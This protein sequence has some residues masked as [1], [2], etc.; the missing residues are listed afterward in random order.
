[1]ALLNDIT[2]PQG[3]AY[4]WIQEDDPQQL[5]AKDEF[6]LQRYALATMYYSLQENGPWATCGEDDNSIQNSTLCNGRKRVF[7]PEEGDEDKIVYEEIPDEGK[8]LSAEHECTWFGVFC[9]EDGSVVI[10]EISESA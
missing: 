4:K 8:W 7:T 10:I 1:V 5:S 6:L 2:T 9:E 3:K